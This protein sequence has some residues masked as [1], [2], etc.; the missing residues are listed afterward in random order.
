MTNEKNVT[1]VSRITRV[2]ALA[3]IAMFGATTFTPAQ[4]LVKATFTLTKDTR[5][6]NTVLLAGRYTASVEPISGMRPV[7]SSMAIVLRPESGNGHVASVLATASREGCEGGLTLQTE[8]NGFS[9]QSMCLD[10]Q[11]LVLHFD[12]SHSG[13]LL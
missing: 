6:G 5:F 2:L 12:L 9:A 1:S 7:G 3:V 10:K 13:N 11:Q 8:G 4:E